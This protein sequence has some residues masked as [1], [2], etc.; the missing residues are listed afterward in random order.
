MRGIIGNATIRGL[1]PLRISVSHRR[2]PF[3][4]HRPSAAIAFTET[5]SH[6]QVA[7]FVRGERS[8]RTAIIP[9][10]QKKAPLLRAALFHEGLFFSRSASA[11]QRDHALRGNPSLRNGP[12]IDAASGPY[13]L[14][15]CRWPGRHSPIGHLLM[16]NVRSE[17]PRRHWS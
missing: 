10:V 16:T 4:F 13:R 17:D 6:F 5:A 9:F 8:R 2:A 7:V 11:L 3:H 1:C 14:L 12:R 15:N